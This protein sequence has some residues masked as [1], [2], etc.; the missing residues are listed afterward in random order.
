[1]KRPQQPGFEP[2][3]RCSPFG[4]RRRHTKNCRQKGREFRGFLG[5]GEYRNPLDHVLP[6]A[7]ASLDLGADK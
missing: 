4:I 5:R 1:M 6:L 7:F 2:G 3:T